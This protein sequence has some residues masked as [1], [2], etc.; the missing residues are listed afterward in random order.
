MAEADGEFGS[1]IALTLGHDG[2]VKLSRHFGGSD[3]DLGLPTPPL[4]SG[5]LH[6]LDH[7]S[8]LCSVGEPQQQSNARNKISSVS[9]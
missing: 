5:L 2:G 1:R 3:H 6:Q 7:R 8:F 9:S 4:G